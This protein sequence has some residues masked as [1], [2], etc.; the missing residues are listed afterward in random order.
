MQRHWVCFRWLLGEPWEEEEE[1]PPPVT[2]LDVG[3]SWQPMNS[4]LSLMTAFSPFSS[5]LWILEE[6]SQEQTVSAWFFWF[7]LAMELQSEQRKTRSFFLHQ[8]SFK[9]TLESFGWG[10]P[11]PLPLL[12]H[13]DLFFFMALFH[14]QTQNPRVRLFDQ[15]VKEGLT[16]EYQLKV[17]EVMSLALFQKHLEQQKYRKSHFEQI[18]Q[19]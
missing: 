3:V 11:G 17:R 2:A 6:T 19:I 18:N 14:T 4:D 13:S 12:D 1:P 15:V 7:V 9:G 10:V 5:E 16:L 8:K